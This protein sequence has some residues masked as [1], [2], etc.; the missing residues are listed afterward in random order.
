[1]FSFTGIH[2]FNAFTPAIASKF[3]VSVQQLIITIGGSA[4]DASVAI[5]PV[6]PSYTVIYFGNQSIDQLAEIY[7]ASS[8]IVEL[9][10]GDTVTVYRGD[11]PINNSILR[12]VCTVVEYVPGFVTSVQYVQPVLG[13]TDF[14]GDVGI[15]AVDLTRSTIVWGGLYSNSNTLGFYGLGTIKFLTN[16]DI[17]TERFASSGSLAGTAF[18][19]EFGATY[20]QSANSYET[21]ISGGLTATETITSAVKEN[22]M[23][24]YNGVRADTKAFRGGFS[25]M[26]LTSNTTVDLIKGEDNGPTTCCFIVLEF[27]STIFAANRQSGV[28]EILSLPDGVV[29]N[30]IGSMF[31][32]S[33]WQGSW[34]TADNDNFGDMLAS[35]EVL[36]PTDLQFIRQWL[37][38]STNIGWEAYSFQ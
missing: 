7:D 12:V 8:A 35:V 13:P 27:Q 29:I 32:F 24:H 28:Y 15:S 21:V 20:I 30:D 10:A 22:S 33:Q 6:N 38:N 34:V 2:G 23:L 25:S 36:D 3:I 16:T 4:T 18:V 1:M 9:T 11:F 26:Q 19:V 17:Q 31:G 5:A 37:I 14:T